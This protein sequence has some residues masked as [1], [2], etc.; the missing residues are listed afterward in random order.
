EHTPDA[1]YYLLIDADLARTASAADLLL[2]PVLAGEAEMTVGSLP[3][4]GGK[5]GFGT[6]KKMSA[7]GIKRACGLAVRAPLSGQ[8][9]VRAEFVRG[10]TAAERFGL[11]VAMTIDVVRAG[12][13]VL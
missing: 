4:A 3:P 6:I 1:E 12:G 11:E 9:A 10:L 5:A 7:K 13:R 2:D 8:R